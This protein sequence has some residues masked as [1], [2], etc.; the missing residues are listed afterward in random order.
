MVDTVTIGIFGKESNSLDQICFQQKANIANIIA[1]LTKA[2]N[3]AGCQPPKFILSV[4]LVPDWSKQDND[5][6][7]PDYLSQ[8]Q[9]FFDRMH[10]VYGNLGCEIQDFYEDGH[11]TI[12]EKDY[13]H[14]L[15]SLGSNLDIIKIR[16][17]INHRDDNHLQLDSNTQIYSFNQLYA[18]TFQQQDDA[19]AVNHYTWHS[20]SPS[21]KIVY[22]SSSGQLGQAFQNQYLDFINKNKHDIE[23]KKENAIYEQ[24]YANG[25]LQSGLV[26]QFSTH[27][28][29][30]YQANVDDPIYKL[31][32]D[33][34]VSISMSWLEDKEMT[35]HQKIQTLNHL[36][37]VKLGH[38]IF[39][40]QCFNYLV[41]KYTSPRLHR[42]I[43]L[44][45]P[46]ANE[47][48]LAE[49]QK[50]LLQLHTISNK[51][52][53]YAGMSLFYNHIYQDHPEFLALLANMFTETEEGEKLVK[54]LFDCSVAQLIQ[55]PARL[56]KNYQNILHNKEFQSRYSQL[57]NDDKE[58]VVDQNANISKS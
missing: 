12:D 43:E 24:A 34:I 13:M 18:K 11:L 35:E 30:F 10:D 6:H 25:F 48:S 40:F 31:T 22:T 8:K 57:V 33:V 41:K 49:S 47:Y 46:V 29:T 9:L 36:P 17:I 1:Q 39:D 26:T 54:E 51:E 27:K 7:H 38:A 23:I 45:A 44:N 16:A 52:L 4:L 3:E 58:H 37:G 42:M 21:S 50:R 19:L 28:K 20:V 14:G 55:S 15:V 2:A 56:A 32:D 53:D 5:Y